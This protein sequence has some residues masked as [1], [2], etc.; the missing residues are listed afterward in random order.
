[1]ALLGI[2]LRRFL[3]DL[4][5][6]AGVA[7]IAGAAVVLD[8]WLTGLWFSRMQVDPDLSR[9]AG[10]VESYGHV[11]HDPFGFGGLQTVEPWRIS[12]PKHGLIMPSAGFMS[13]YLTQCVPST[14]VAI[15]T[16]GVPVVVLSLL[17]L[18]KFVSPPTNNA[19]QRKVFEQ[20]RSQSAPFVSIPRTCPI[21]TETVGALDDPDYLQAI[22][23]LLRRW[24]ILRATQTLK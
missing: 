10:P 14:L 15:L 12:L 3:A 20:L 16:F 7:G 19:C 2:R 8:L 21:L 17:A 6:R 9:V 4:A 22:T 24:E 23:K 11:L 5:S 13:S 1:M 18:H